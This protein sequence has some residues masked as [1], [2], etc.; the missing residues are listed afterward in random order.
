MTE[1]VMETLDHG[2]PI[3]CPYLGNEKLCREVERRAKH[4]CRFRELCEA[5]VVGRE[6][7]DEPHA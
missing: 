3:L 7:R 4:V 1:H 6:Y 2:L 5:T